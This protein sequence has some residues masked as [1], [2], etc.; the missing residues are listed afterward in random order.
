[1]VPGTAID[2]TPVH[3]FQGADSLMFEE[4]SPTGRRQI[5]RMNLSVG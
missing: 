1:M 2:Y 3:G 4:V 5:V